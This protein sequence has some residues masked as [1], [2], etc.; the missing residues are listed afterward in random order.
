MTV[1]V[2]A[3]ITSEAHTG[4]YLATGENSSHHLP[5]LSTDLLVKLKTT[6]PKMKETCSLEDH[7]FLLFSEVIGSQFKLLMWE[8]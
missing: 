4:T 7:E 8:V 6:S 3:T 2:N 5:P 1:D